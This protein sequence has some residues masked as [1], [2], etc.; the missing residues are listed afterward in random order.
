[1]PS[2]KIMWT[3]LPNGFDQSPTGKQMKISVFVSP[4]LDPQV[5]PQ[6]L[7]T[8][9]D[10]LAWPATVIKK[11]KFSVE[12]QNGP[13][14]K[15]ERISKD[16][17]GGLYSQIFRP[18]TFVRGY[19]FKD[20]RHRIIRSYPVRNVLSYLRGVYRTIAE[21]APTD[22]PPL[23]F[24]DN[25]NGTLLDFTRDLGGIVDTRRPHKEKRLTDALSGG[26]LLVAPKAL[27]PLAP[28]LNVDHPL[29]LFESRRELDF[30]QLD[31]F[32]D[33]P[34]MKSDY[35]RHPKVELVPPPLKPSEFDFHQM[36]AA[37]GDYPELLR[38]LGFVIDLRV[39]LSNIPLNRHPAG[40]RM[41]TAA[42]AA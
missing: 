36:V 7:N 12:F 6:R 38:R 14:V 26:G 22:L 21:E 33:R 1:M 27:N 15:A 9:P 40:C 10:F 29:G 39:P 8:F 35:M 42:R 16:P 25:P 32:F 34:E 41:G 19:K 20:Y 23:P 31:R 13:T 17:D 37:L 3:L 5:A 11:L 28:A 24:A 30:F 4:R 2:Q 18:D